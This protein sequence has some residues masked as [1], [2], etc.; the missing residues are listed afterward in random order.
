MSFDLHDFSEIPPYLYGK[1]DFARVHQSLYVKYIQYRLH[2]YHPQIAFRR[3]FGDAATNHN[4]H[5]KAEAMESNPVV[6]HNLRIAIRD[7][8][9]AELWDEK[10][11]IHDLLEMA[12]NVYEK[13]NVRLAAMKELNVLC[14]ITVT[15]E[16]GNTKR[17]MT[18]DEYYKTHG[19]TPAD[20]EAK[21]P[22]DANLSAPPAIH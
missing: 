11:A 17:G 10:I 13:G 21:R 16:K 12:R 3:V 8:N 20:A 4:F 9:T 14:G 15:D 18:L 1:E 19:T 2:G 6:I 5:V 22:D 7:T